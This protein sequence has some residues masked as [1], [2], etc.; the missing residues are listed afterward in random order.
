MHIEKH[1]YSFLKRKEAS[2]EKA[3]TTIKLWLH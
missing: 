2:E 1:K 3:R